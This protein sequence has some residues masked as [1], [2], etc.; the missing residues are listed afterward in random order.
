MLMIKKRDLMTTPED[1]KNVDSKKYQRKTRSKPLA[2]STIN[3]YEIIDELGRGTMGVVYLAWDPY[4]KRNVA[5]KTSI[6]NS[7]KDREKFFVEAQ[8]AGKLIH[9]NIISIFDVGETSD[10]CYIAMEYI[11]GSTLKP[12]IDK[13]NLLKPEKTISIVLKLCD[14]LYYAQ[15]QNVIHR[16]I[17]PANIM[18][19][20]NGIPKITDFGLAVSARKSKKGQMAGTPSYMSPEELNGKTVSF[21]SDIFSLGVTFYELLTGQRA[22][23]GKH[24]EEI[25]DN[26]LHNEPEPIHK[27]APQLP[28]IAQN[29]IQR[30]LSKSPLGR[31]GSIL[32]FASELEVMQRSLS[33]SMKQ[34]DM[35]NTVNLLLHM[36]FFKEFNS[37]Q[38]KKLISVTQIL[39]IQAGNVIVSEGDIDD[40][41]FIILSGSV[42]I[43]NTDDDIIAKIGVG[44]LF[45]ELSFLSQHTR[46]ASVMADVNCVML[47]VNANILN[48]LPIDIQL[49]F[50]KNFAK[51]LVKRFT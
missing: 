5:I 3:R 27:H 7:I 13:N 19:T 30:A 16:D 20:K 34:K 36:D 26:I 45:G 11:E 2:I 51:T 12:Y 50:Y 40:T 48:K 9:P 35:S 17:K 8:S 47:K 32:E 38:L 4:I 1:T 6:L 18:L 44:D 42:S 49:L 15:R 23:F 41:I 21:S 43:I 25:F 14:A 29:I 24:I 37:K 22:F 33:G 39:K 10:F 28:K 46:K 31:Y